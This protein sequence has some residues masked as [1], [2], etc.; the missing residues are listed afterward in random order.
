MKTRTMG[1]LSL[2][3]VRL[4]PDL[5]CCR[6][7]LAL[8]ALAEAVEEVEAV[9]VAGVVAGEAEAAVRRSLLRHRRATG[10]SLLAAELRLP[11]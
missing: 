1:R 5:R 2:R 3:V 9:V 8:E 11:G 4:Q 6:R 7:P 10:H